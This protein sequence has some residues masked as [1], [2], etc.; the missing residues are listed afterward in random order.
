MVKTGEKYRHFK[1]GIYQIV[2][3]AKNSE[4]LEDMVVYKSV[5]EPEKI[6]VRPLCMWDETVCRGGVTFKRFEKL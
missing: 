6:W 2:C 5:T 4:S 1:G 3:V